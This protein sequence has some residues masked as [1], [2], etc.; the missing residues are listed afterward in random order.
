M[1]FL[2]YFTQFLVGTGHSLLALGVLLIVL[3]ACGWSAP[4]GSEPAPSPDKLAEII[5]RKTLIIATDP[6]WL[7]QSKLDEGV[8]RAANTKCDSNQFTANQFE[9]FDVAVAVEVAGRL[10]VEPCFVTPAW[11]LIT[12]GN[13]DDRW[14]IHV[15]SMTIVPER[16]EVLYFTQPYYTSPAAFFVHKDNATFGKPADLSGK[17]IGVCTGCIYEKYLDGTLTIP[18]EEPDFVVKN[19]VIEGYQTEALENLVLGD[20]VEL[21]AVL[22]QL[23][24]GQEAIRAGQPV[25]QLGQPV[26]NEYLAIAID[27]KHSKDPVSLA[28]KVSEIVQQMHADGRLQQLSE[29]YY[30]LDL[31]TAAGQFELQSVQQLP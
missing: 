30:G 7:P 31:T 10:G 15:G 27:K 12:S 1:N 11:T 24:A 13:W 14:D 18:G 4:A 22:T 21:D 29:Q 5:A 23:T 16:I 17:R 20:G 28:R 25:K 26:F 2:K 9:G 8:A 3:A 6:D 19:S